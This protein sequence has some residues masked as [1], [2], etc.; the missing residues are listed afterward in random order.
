MSERFNQ[1]SIF[2]PETVFVCVC[3]CWD[4][5][6]P[7]FLLSAVGWFEGGKKKEARQFSAENTGFIQRVEAA[8][9]A[10]DEEGG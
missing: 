9:L 2:W 10:G 1:P 4:Y 8:L 3:V 6:F 5:L 7:W